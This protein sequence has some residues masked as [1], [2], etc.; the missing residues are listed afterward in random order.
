MPLLKGGGPLMEFIETIFNIGEIFMFI[1]KGIDYVVKFALWLIQF[2][3][4]FISSNALP[5]LSP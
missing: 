3:I 1:L 5:K 4:W 2:I